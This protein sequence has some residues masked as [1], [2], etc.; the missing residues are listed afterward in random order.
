MICSHGKARMRFPGCAA[1]AIILRELANCLYED[2]IRSTRPGER[3]PAANPRLV[4]APAQAFPAAGGWGSG[5]GWRLWC[6]DRR[7]A[8]GQ[9]AHVQRASEDP[10]RGRTAKGQAHQTMDILQARRSQDKECQ[11]DHRATRLAAEVLP[12]QQRMVRCERE[13]LER[14]NPVTYRRPIRRIAN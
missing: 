10:P 8:R 7:E 9:P 1:F 6:V 12:Y 14:M 13:V 5:R 11:A 2:G 3:T 4:E